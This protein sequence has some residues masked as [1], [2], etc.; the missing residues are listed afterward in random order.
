MG[1][2]W[3]CWE[4]DI[5]KNRTVSDQSPLKA[6]VPLNLSKYPMDL[7]DADYGVNQSNLRTG[8][9]HMNFSTTRR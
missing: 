8:L 6:G 1:I 2:H 7:K 4:I 9:T 3:S 5:A